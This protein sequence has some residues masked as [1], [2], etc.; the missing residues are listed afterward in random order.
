FLIPVKGTPL[1]SA[2]GLS[3]VD[4]IKTIALFRI[5]LKNK[6]IKIAAGRESLL[7]DFQALGFLAGA[8]GMLIGGYL[9]VK[10]RA[11]EEDLKLAREVRRIWT[12]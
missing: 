9:T 7:K 1:G 8:N 10:G 6:A 5:I 2:G 11:L 4:A 3:C 12:K